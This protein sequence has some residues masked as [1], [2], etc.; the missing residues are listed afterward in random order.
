MVLDHSVAPP[1]RP[2]RQL[3]AVGTVLGSHCHQLALYLGTGLSLVALGTTELYFL[4]PNALAYPAEP[5]W[6]LA[7]LL[8]IV[9]AELVMEHCVSNNQQ[10]TD[11]APLPTANG[12]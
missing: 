10:P 8:Q 1:C 2:T 12:L 5:D 7:L 11:S 4:G 6:L 9:Q 3:D